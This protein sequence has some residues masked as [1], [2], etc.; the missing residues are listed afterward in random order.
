MDQEEVGPEIIGALN[1]YLEHGI[2]PGSFLTA[3][4]E[5]DLFEAMARADS[6]NQKRIF[7]ICCYIYKHFPL[8]SYGSPE[9]VNR[10]LKHIDELREARR[11]L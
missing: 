9:A 1:R 7:K 8:G 11:Q 6:V 3:V 4:L 2:I 10:Y 5:N